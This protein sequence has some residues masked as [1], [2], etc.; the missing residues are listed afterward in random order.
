MRKAYTW[1]TYRVPT[2]VLREAVER[3]PLRKA[4]ICQRL[5]WV[6]KH[7]AYHPPDLSRL[8]R[9]IGTRPDK[10]VYRQTTKPEIAAAI[11]R[12]CDFDPVDF[13]L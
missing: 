4:E 8:E 11:I 2:A 13:G 12:A 5:G 1:K 7:R 6:S 9:T 10:G 3:S